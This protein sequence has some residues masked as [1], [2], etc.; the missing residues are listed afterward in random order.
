M[1]ICLQSLPQNKKYTLSPFKTNLWQINSNLMVP[2]I[3]K[4]NPLF[5]ELS[6]HFYT[7]WGSEKE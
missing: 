6:L 2:P 1:H 4:Y 7:Y 5:A 3:D